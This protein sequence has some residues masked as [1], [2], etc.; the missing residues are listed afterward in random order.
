MTL[1]FYKYEGA[2][3]DFIIIDNRNLNIA[4]DKEKIQSLCLRH[5]GVGSDGLMFLESVSKNTP[6]VADQNPE[7]LDFAMRFYNPDGS[8]G[9]MCGNGGRCIVRFAKDIGAIQGKETTFLAPDGIHSAEILA[10]EDI[11]LKM[12]DVDSWETYPDG[13]WID[14]GTSHFVVKSKDVKQEDIL[15]RGRELRYNKRFLQHNGTNV[16]FY[17]EIKQNNLLIRT[18][19][20][21]V[22]DETLACGTG[23][24]ATAL[25]YAIDKDF[26]DGDYIIN[27]ATLHNNL[28]VKFF[29]KENSFKDIYL[30]GP[31][32]K[33]FEGEI[34]I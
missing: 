18:Y 10:N 7:K 33:V 28:S 6:T 30:I 34:K 25:C 32:T 13:Y 3:N 4:L 11:S 8:S 17:T 19:E 14:T 23:I 9:M 15:L 12:K 27:V 21:G 24:T 2:G 20:R 31:A 16:N 29:K 22:E 5:F 26:K 1:H